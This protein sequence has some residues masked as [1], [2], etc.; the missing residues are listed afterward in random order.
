VKKYLAL[1]L[2]KRD[3]R[4]STDHLLHNTASHP[5]NGNQL[6]A[7]FK[8]LLSKEPD[9]AGSFNFHRLRHSWATN[10][11]N[12]GMELAVLKELGG[13]EKW[14]SMQR[15]IKVLD[16]TVRR[17]YEAAY[18]KQQEKLESGEDET[19]TLL[20]FAMMDE[21]GCNLR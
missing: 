15:Y 16:V 12:N 11:M 18:A 20:D 1:W 4:C 2:A 9:P 10:L 13:W 19:L 8:N 21:P 3:P 14:N 17:Q 6:D 7:W 5:F